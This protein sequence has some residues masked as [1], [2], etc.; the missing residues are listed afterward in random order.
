MFRELTFTIAPFTW[1]CGSA[2]IPQNHATD[3]MRREITA[4]MEN[5][6]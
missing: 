2:A 1:A 6:K 3:L 4:P 5:P